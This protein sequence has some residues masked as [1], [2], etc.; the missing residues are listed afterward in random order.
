MSHS[1]S[2]S[3]MVGVDLTATGALE[4][5]NLKFFRLVYGGDSCITNF[6]GVHTVERSEKIPTHF[7]QVPFRCKFSVRDLWAC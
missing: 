5:L 7:V 6:G 1:A 4:G 3:P 2:G